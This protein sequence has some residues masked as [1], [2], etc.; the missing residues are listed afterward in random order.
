[1]TPD[2]TPTRTLDT[3]GLFCPLPII[4]TAETVRGM[5]VGDVL[6][7]LATDFGILEDMPAWCTATGQEYLG[8]V[9]DGPLYRSY[10]RRLH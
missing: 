2:P 10:V 4:R 7:V 6:E 9:T 8:T 3:T 5:D 1:V